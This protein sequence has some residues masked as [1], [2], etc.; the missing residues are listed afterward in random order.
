MTGVI[1]IH[2]IDT[3]QTILTGNEFIPA[4]NADGDTVKIKISSIKTT[5]TKSDIGLDN[6]INLSP[7]NFPI[8]I[9]VQTAL[10]TKS[11]TGHTH[12]GAD[13]IDLNSIIDTRVATA[14][15]L[16]NVDVDFVTE[17]W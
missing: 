6:V 7:A 13:I 14:I 12:V 17:D 1:K 10:E 9:A 8:S 5:I 15:D 2:Q 3:E 11:N 4:S 16:L